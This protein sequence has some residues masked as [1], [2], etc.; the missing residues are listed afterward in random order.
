MAR[1]TV[2]A[3]P[4]IGRARADARVGVMLQLLLAMTVA[5]AL[6]LC[7]RAIDRTKEV[8]KLARGAVRAT[9]DRSKSEKVAAG[10]SEVSAIPTDWAGRGRSAEIGSYPGAYPASALERLPQSFVDDAQITPV[11]PVR[12]DR[13]RYPA[14]WTMRHGPS[15]TRSI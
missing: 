4:P 2:T 9:F 12:P 13:A 14:A 5:A 3:Y 10:R 7:S 15:A 6:S 11:Q 8:L 1:K